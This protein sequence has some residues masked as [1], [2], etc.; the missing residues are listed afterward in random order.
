ME[1]LAKIIDE[2]GYQGPPILV[3]ITATQIWKQLPYLITY[4]VGF[5]LNKHLNEFLKS[6]FREPRPEPIDLKKAQERDL[7]RFIKD[8]TKH[9][10]GIYISKAHIYGMPSGHAETA[11]YALAFYY[12]MKEKQIK[13]LSFSPM[14]LSTIIFLIMLLIFITTLYQRWYSKEHSIGQLAMGSLIGAS[15]AG[16]LFY[17][18]KKYL[19]GLTN[20]AVPYGEVN[21]GN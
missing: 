1:N 3:F 17:I 16:I 4:L 12:F 6:I 21:K 15:F 9:K 5:F 19:R 13:S 7:F 2:L 18:T 8:P 10:D 14:N 20:K 11:S